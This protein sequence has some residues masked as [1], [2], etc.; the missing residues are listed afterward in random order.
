MPS[1]GC[2]PNI[3]MCITLVYTSTMKKLSIRAWIS[4][5]SFILIAG[6]LFFS[7]QE[8]AHAWQ[9][10][11]QVNLWILALIV[12]LTALSYLAEGE[13]VF[14]YLRSK[15]FIHGIKPWTLMRVSL[16]MNFVNH[17]LPSGG[18][19]GISYGTWRMG[20]FGVSSGRATMAQMVRYV[21]G[22]GATI[23]L[24]VAS[25]IMVTVDNGV[26]RW[27]ILMSSAL[28]SGMII[29]TLLAMYVF[30]SPSRIVAVAA[31]LAR[32]LNRIVRAVTFGR[33]KT[34]LKKATIEAFFMEM[35]DD[36]RTLVKD[37][38]LLIGPFLWGIVFMAIAIGQFWVTFLSLGEPVNPASILIGYSLASVAGF[39]VATPGGVGAYEFV[40][41][42]V[43]GASGTKQGTAIA[44][45]TLARIMILLIT[46]A[47]GY[48]YYQ[49][50]ILKYGK[51]KTPV[52]R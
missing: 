12:P 11:G 26:N 52:Q 32:H 8:V 6:V 45:V 49:A 51:R 34:L 37:K 29:V 22:F 17:L 39:A 9:L 48:V 7:R 28:V 13:M 27:M 4:I 43:L 33:V 35:H 16:E 38:R 15:K 18:V 44:G 20:R 23:V 14:S 1:A 31:Y 5:V 46:I 24:L 3:A 50:T 19:S 25:V 42:L 36:Y 2:R 21:A 10:M 41:V 30:K 40:M 47:L